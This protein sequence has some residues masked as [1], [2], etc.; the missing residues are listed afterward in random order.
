MSE[1]KYRSMPGQMSGQMSGHMY[2]TILS[3]SWSTLGITRSK[4]NCSKLRRGNGKAYDSW[5][6]RWVNK[7]EKG[8]KQSK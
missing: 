2:V 7:C 4:M 6:V 1:Y 5:A 3:D 8:Q